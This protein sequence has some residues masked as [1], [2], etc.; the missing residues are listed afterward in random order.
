M[1]TLNSRSSALVLVDYQERLMPMIPEGSA[2]VQRGVFLARTAQ[3]LNIPVLGTEQNPA[4]LG[5]N[6]AELKALCS[7]TLAKTH[8]DAFEDGLLAALHQVH[9]ALDQVVLAG[10][11]AHVCL[12]QTALG[13]LRAGLRVWVVGNACGS[14]R[15]SDHAAALQRLAQA[16]AT[17]VTHEMAAFEW[18]H[19]CEHPRFR[20][21]LALI[22]ALE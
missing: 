10:C 1:D 4:R 18:L 3:I 17:V 7:K 16:G 12:L 19:H 11:E 13:A 9:P 15:A 22:K 20:E 8:F 6:A 5:P 2:A 21:V 14:R